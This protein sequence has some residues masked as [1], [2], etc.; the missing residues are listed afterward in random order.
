MVATDAGGVGLFGAPQSVEI[1]AGELT[2]WRARA[3][4]RPQAGDPEGEC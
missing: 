1:V 2:S 4:S 3:V